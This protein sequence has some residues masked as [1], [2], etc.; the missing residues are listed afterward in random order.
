MISVTILTRN[1]AKYLHEVLTST[2][3]FDEVVLY[4]SGSNDATFEIA[5]QFPNVVVYKG[6]FIGFGPTHNV[7]SNLAKHDWI[8][9]IDSDE[10]VT[11]KMAQEIKALQL[12]AQCVYSFPRDNYYNGTHI[13]WCGWCPDRQYRLYN[14][15]KTRF[16]DAQVH[17]A[18]IIKNMQH[19]P[20]NG[21]IIHYS[22]AS[23]SDFLGKMQTYSELFAKQNQGKKKSSPTKA[24]LH[25]WF[26]FFK[27]YILKKGI[28]GGYEGFVISAYN[29][30][31]AFYK[32]L[33]LYEA[34]QRLSNKRR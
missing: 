14:R 17:E 20:L 33:K 13:R 15:T 9:S 31:T 19:L 34:N 24:V 7:A 11:P 21:A 27:S 30:H 2:Q 22:Y 4:D 12:D 18:V 5:K 3:H 28:L 25:G 26:A 23:L 6:E 10:V 8:L 29:G 16:T 1:S 32:Y